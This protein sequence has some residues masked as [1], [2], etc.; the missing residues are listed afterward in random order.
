MKR[1]LG[2][3]LGLAAVVQ[4]A[5][6]CAQSADS[7]RQAS[8]A[9]QQTHPSDSRHE[10]AGPKGTAEPRASR[11]SSEGGGPPTWGEAA[12]RNDG[13]ARSNGGQP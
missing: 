11:A 6:V 3:A 9:F 2:A 13:P 7:P 10:P 5:A 4:A 8:G 1:T 12:K